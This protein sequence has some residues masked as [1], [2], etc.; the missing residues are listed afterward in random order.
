MENKE[1]V[2]ELKQIVIVIC[3]KRGGGAEARKEFTLM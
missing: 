1:N 3:P 2:K